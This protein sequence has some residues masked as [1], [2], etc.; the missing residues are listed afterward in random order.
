MF[1]MLLVV[2]VM[3]L[4]P[5]QRTQEQDA[6]ARFF[7]W[8]YWKLTLVTL[9]SGATWFQSAEMWSSVSRIVRDL[10]GAIG[11]ERRST[12][13]GYGPAWVSPFTRIV[14][15]CT[16]SLSVLWN[17]RSTVTPLTVFGPLFASVPS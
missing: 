6:L 1:E 14:S 11:A 2:C 5:A 17:V 10:P 3:F 7:G 4:P 12:M 8:R 13:S 15:F 9:M 16:T